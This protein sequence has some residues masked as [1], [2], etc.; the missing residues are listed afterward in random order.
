MARQNV[1][2]QAFNRGLVSPKSLGRV[3]L[4]RTRLSAEIYKNW[5]P[6]TQGA[7]TIRPG[8]KYFGNSYND[9]GAQWIEFVASTDDTALLE[10][11]HQKMRIWQGG[12]SHALSLLSRPKVDTTLS[13]SDTGWADASTG[14][15]S[16][17][18]VQTDIIPMM[19][20]ATTDGVTISA[21]SEDIITTN[22]NFSAAAWKVGDD[23]IVSAWF[24][25]GDGSASTL[26]SWLKIDFGSVKAVTSYSIR[27][28]SVAANIDNAP[29]TWTLEGNDVDTGAGWTV[30]DTRSG[31][32]GWSVSEKRSYTITDTGGST[33]SWRYWRLNVSAVDG[34]TELIISEIEMF[35]DTGSANSSSLTLNANGTGALAR[36]KKHV[37]VDTG[38]LDV[39]HSLVLRVD[40]GP[41]TLRVGSSDG[42][43]D[44]ISETSLATGYHNL[45]FTPSS[46]FYVSLQTTSLVNRVIGSMGIGDSGT[47]EITAPWAASNLDDIRYDQSADVVYVD[48]AGI[49]PSKIER[50]GTGR[51]WSIVDYAPN[52]GPFLPFPSNS[53][54]LS[55]SHFYGNTTLNSDIPLFSPGHAGS[56]IRA[57][58]EGQGGQWALGALDAKTDPIE[59]VGISD[60]DT[61]TH[62]ANNERRI[63]I[64]ASGTWAGAITIERSFDDPEFGFKTLSTQIFATPTDTGTFTA[65][66]DDPEDNIR[67]W[68]RARISSYTSGTAIVTITYNAGGVTGIA[69]ITGYNSNTDVDVEVLSRFSDTGVTD[70]W[71]LGYWSTARGFPTSVA[72]HGGRLAHGQGGSVFLSVADDFESFDEAV[73]GDAGPIIRTLGSGPVDNIFYLVSLL[74]LVIG[75]AGAEITMRSSAID[76]PLTPDNS[77]AVPFSTQGS[78][79][80]RAVKMDTRAI[81]VQRSGQRVFMIGPA[82][83]TLADYEGFELTLLVP[84]LLEIGVVSIA[85]QR[86]PD[87]RIHCV[88]ADGRVAILTYEPTE[89][90]ICWSIWETDGSVEQA[91]VLPGLTEDA[92]YYHINRTINSATKRFLEKWALESECMGDTGL[93]W[94][95]DCASSYT[96]TGRTNSLTDIATHLVGSSVILW[97]DLDTGSTP[98]VDLSP[99]VAGVQTTYTVDTGG[100]VTLS[101]TEGVHHAV[102]GL[103][104]TAD[105]RSTKLA[106]AAE[107]GTALTQMKR[108]A[109]VGLVL[110]QTHNR[111]LQIGSD[112][113]NLDSLPQII[114]QGGPVDA[115]K[116]FGTFEDFAFSINSKYSADERLHIRAKAPRP[117]TVLA[118][119][120]S[121]ET[122]ERV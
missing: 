19:T 8:T 85:V 111:A 75:T 93:S 99:D 35:A 70:N 31:Q 61:G 78:A 6:K 87:T 100:D 116:I 17:V 23:D 42:D 32:T 47:V 14:G 29:T 24:D 58:H 3:D 48:C 91:M 81:M 82:E 57:F 30:E 2:F 44:Y 112:T 110:F 39:E 5:L 73:E 45:A 102:A 119:A 43:D 117:A 104:F 49:K 113:G 28:G 84:D 68:Y 120:V 54:K 21:S 34:D 55:L 86:Q 92:V 40:R 74:R 18:S 36:R 59:V 90:V 79:N 41:I 62:D 15:A 37:V 67:V 118:A 107:A 115:D 103:P 101:L 20:A 11:T 60:T 76:E 80:L 7:M 121:V 97:G 13:L 25:T 4:D 114:D 109:Q 106:Y 65:T 83:N 77:S 89:E 98:F 63:V 71:Q 38:D 122:N 50:R 52:D 10:I 12:D 64:A 46:D 108:A 66:I 53:A 88:L 69:R 95:M 96:D 33:D 16:T 22:P 1:A 26:P 9:T 105:W 94:I 72:L 56:L 51:S 27:I